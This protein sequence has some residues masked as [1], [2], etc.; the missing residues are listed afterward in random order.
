MSVCLFVVWC[1]LLAAAAVAAGGAGD[2]DVLQVYLVGHS[3][4][5][6]GWLNT[7]EEYYAQQVGEILTHVVAAL[8]RDEQRK[9][10]WAEISFFE[11]WYREQAAPTRAS[12]AQL[13]GDGRLAFVGGGWVQND[14]QRAQSC[15]RSRG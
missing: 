4:C 7:F 11:R 14:G 12:V 5:D 3:H 8:L 13:V 10:V 9:F 15:A 2:T 6:P 1:V